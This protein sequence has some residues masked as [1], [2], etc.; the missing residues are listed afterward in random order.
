MEGDRLEAEVIMKYRAEEAKRKMDKG[1]RCEDGD[2][3]G[4]R[5]R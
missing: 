4:G 1:M 5:R 2:V 3:W